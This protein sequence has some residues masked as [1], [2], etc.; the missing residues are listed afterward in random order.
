MGTLA[1]T[2]WLR[3]EYIGAERSMRSIAEELGVD[4]AT[5]LK[6]LRRHGI[7]TRA[8]RPSVSAGERYGRL[9]VVAEHGRTTAGKRTYACLC[10]CG[11]ERIVIG[12]NL[13]TGTS[14]SCGCYGREVAAATRRRTAS[15]TADKIRVHGHSS[16]GRPSSPTYST[17]ANM[18]QRCTN[19]NQPNWPFYGGRGIKVCDRW[20]YSF[21]DFLA[22][23]GTRPDGLTIERIDNNGDYAPGNCRWATR[24]EQANNRRPR[25]RRP[26][27]PPQA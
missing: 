21:V 11:T 17:W 27:G 19:P 3:Q 15:E 2:E 24:K 13:K 8:Q 1:D 20:R 9:I 26:S 7:S 14:T 4:P 25:R 16:F 5:V 12:N 6:A 23:M 18:V 10:D 22:D